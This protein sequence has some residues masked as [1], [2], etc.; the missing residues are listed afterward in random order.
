[1]RFT[2]RPLGVSRLNPSASVTAI[3][4]RPPPESSAS[5]F[6]GSSSSPE[7]AGKLV[8][9]GG[10]IKLV[11]LGKLVELVEFVEAEASLAAAAPRCGSEEPDEQAAATQTQ[12]ATANDPKAIRLS[13]A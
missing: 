2:L 10:L 6:D 8:E 13:F 12:P 1:M 11:E 4:P 5:G 7:A 9:L 3:R